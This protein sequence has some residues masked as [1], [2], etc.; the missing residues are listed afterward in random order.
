M[1]L[2][3]IDTIPEALVIRD[4]PITI[5]V[6]IGMFLSFA[7]IA[8]AKLVKPD[9]YSVLMISFIKNK[10]LYNYIRESFPPQKGG[11]ILLIFNYLV[12]FS[13]LVIL[14]LDIKSIQLSGDFL[15]AI[16][17]PVAFFIFHFLSLYLI[18]FISGDI[19]VV[20]TPI[21]MKVNG[22]QFIG[23]ACSV[24]VF[25]WS[26]NFISRELFYEMV[27]SLFIFEMLT[28]IIRSFIYVL[29]AGV[30]WYYIIMYFCTLE[31]LPLFIMYYILTIA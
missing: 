26:L 10:G 27:L 11:S 9:V 31:I 8:L 2:A 15:L 7:L 19:D 29:A 18:G 30:S 13:L 17:S 23:L 14:V 6:G 3:S 25:S 28:R 5:I 20:K 16:I 1:L 22:A 21:L 4:H 12:S 24:L